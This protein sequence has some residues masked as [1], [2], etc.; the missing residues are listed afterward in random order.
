M[1]AFSPFQ[2][3]YNFTDEPQIENYRPLDK[4]L[5]TCAQPVPGKVP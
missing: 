5:N 2:I 4:D 1:S 3:N